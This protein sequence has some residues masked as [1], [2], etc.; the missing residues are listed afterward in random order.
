MSSLVLYSL[1][2]DVIHFLSPEERAQIVAARAEAASRKTA[3]DAATDKV[4]RMCR[5]VCH[6]MG[7]DPDALVIDDIRL[8]AIPQWQMYAYAVTARLKA[9]ALDKVFAAEALQDGG[10]HDP[11]R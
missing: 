6:H 8:P 7:Q 5:A 1:R 3:P 9:K 4:E 11:A 10:G 2:P